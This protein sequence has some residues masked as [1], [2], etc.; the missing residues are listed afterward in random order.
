MGERALGAAAYA[1]KAVSIA[2]PGDVD[3]ELDW[4]VEQMKPD[5][6]AALL[7]L[8]PIG[9]DPAGPL[10]AG[11]CSPAASWGRAFGLCRLGS[12]GKADRAGVG[13]VQPEC[14]SSEPLPT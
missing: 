14:A 12:P 10:A 8:P 11:S 1:V 3:A 13:A 7:L 2:R 5:V 6:R 9:E 4:Q